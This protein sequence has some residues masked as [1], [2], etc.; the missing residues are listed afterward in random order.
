MSDFIY[1]SD[2]AQADRLAEIYARYFDSEL[3]GPAY[4]VA[5]NWG[6]VLACGD[7]YEG[8]Q[9]YEEPALLMI[10]F[11]G[12]LLNL[13]AAVNTNG[14][15]GMTRAL[16]AA[17]REDPHFD[18]HAHVGGPFAA[19][20]VDKGT[21]TVRVVTDSLGVLPVFRAG[22]GSACVFGTKLTPVAHLSPGGASVDE[23]AAC[24]FVLHGKVAFPH[25]LYNGVERLAPGLDCTRDPSGR[26]RERTYWRPLEENRY[27]GIDE[28]A[29]DLSDRIVE[30]VSRIVAGRP[31]IAAFLSG[32]E[33]S[34]TLLA[35]LP[36]GLEVHCFTVADYLN[37]EARTARR[38]AS[39]SGHS[40]V[41]AQRSADH[42]IKNFDYAC[43][44]VG[45]ETCLDQLH[46]LGLPQTL[47]LGT[48]EAVLSGTCADYLF[49]GY[50]VDMIERKIR[51]F[52]VWPSR[53]T[54]VTE[55]G[56]YPH[57]EHHMAAL[58]AILTA[59]PA[60]AIAQRNW[61]HIELVRTFRP[62]SV[63]EW[64]RIWP[65]SQESG[66]CQLIQT[67]RCFRSY[68]P[69]IMN[70][71]IDISCSVPVAWKLNRRLYHR[72]FHKLVGRLGWMQH[73]DGWF[74]ALGVWG[75]IAAAVPMGGFRLMERAVR[76]REAGGDYAWP[77]WLSLTRR[78]LFHGLVEEFR[79][80][81]TP[82]AGCFRQDEEALFA[83]DSLLPTQKLRLLQ[84]LFYLREA[85]S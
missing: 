13:A 63:A 7:L 41:L 39:M 11:G 81:F 43:R 46:F 71:I 59:E 3:G 56:V 38:A 57:F 45:S 82:L 50:T 12:P 27:S 19:V 70:N 35:T 1:T 69:F 83:G 9:P 32:G 24:E 17:S 36:P 10:V 84:V 22:R 64:R 29:R 61:R 44:V 75:N 28:A 52:K 66:M 53:E 62:R 30:N 80:E 40:W 14:P 8:F 58:S 68:V 73:A 42:Y 72:A 4:Q 54:P 6:A 15:N 78:P 18:W 51:G 21:G 85:R 16:L 26:W 77:V 31:R 23:V 76:K 20:T 37:R 74:P 5:G 47:G 25:T 48:F 65:A 33:D 49:K 2:P 55:R 60:D 67:T 34:R 79:D